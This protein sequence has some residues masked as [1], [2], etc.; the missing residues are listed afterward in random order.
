MSDFG[1][2]Y[3]LFSSKDKKGKVYAFRKH[4]SALSFN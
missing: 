3:D 2:L 4:N 1:N